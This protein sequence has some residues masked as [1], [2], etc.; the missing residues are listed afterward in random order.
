MKYDFFLTFEIVEHSRFL[1]L[2]LSVSLSLFLSVCFA[3]LSLSLRNCLC[4]E[5]SAKFCSTK[6]TSSSSTW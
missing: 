5:F 2:S 3:D 6:F 1:P 4:D